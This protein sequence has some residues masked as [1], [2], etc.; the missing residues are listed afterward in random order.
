MK[1]LIQYISWIAIAALLVVMSFVK[2]FDYSLKLAILS[3][4]SFVQNMAFTLVSRSRNS[5]DPDY[6]RYCA[7]ASNGIWFMCYTFL[8]S[9][10]LQDIR[11]QNWLPIV[12][13]GIVYGLATAEGSVTM[14]RYAIKKEAGKRKVGTGLKADDI[15]GLSEWLR[16][17]GYLTTIKNEYDP[18]W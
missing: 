12:I 17:R 5:G 8:F 2:D 15:E 6:H 1:K 10:I 14:M 13:V 9:S 3:I 4:V 18:K 11:D 16:Q 7:W